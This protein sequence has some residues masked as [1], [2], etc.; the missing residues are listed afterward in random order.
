MKPAIWTAIGSL[1]VVLLLAGC[2]TQQETARPV[3][4]PLQIAA[5]RNVVSGFPSG[6]PGLRARVAR[7]VEQDPAASQEF[8]AAASNANPEQIQAIG[9]GLAD[10]IQFFSRAR[11]YA[12]ANTVQRALTVADK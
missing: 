12:A 9:G 8:V 11:A 1:G 5:A 7:A 4:S 10:A 3:S 6:G 2:G